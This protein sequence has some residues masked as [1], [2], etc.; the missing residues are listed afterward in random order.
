MISVR[1]VS[2]YKKPVS[3]QK[4]FDNQLNCWFW[5]GIFLSVGGP[6][7]NQL[8]DVDECDSRHW[9]NIVV[10]ER[11]VRDSRQ[12]DVRHS[13]ECNVIVR[14]THESDL[15][16]EWRCFR[17]CRHSQ[18]CCSTSRNSINVATWEEIHVPRYV[19]MLCVESVWQRASFSGNS[20][21]EVDFN[22][23]SVI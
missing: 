15:A 22:T 4:K 13:F 9:G 3:Q 14:R 20:S 7:R 16:I 18:Q 19:L 11:N 6:V 1:N 8:R 2:S 17:W 21:Q 12:I 23:H 10:M 5:F